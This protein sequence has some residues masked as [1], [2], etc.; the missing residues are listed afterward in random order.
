[1]SNMIRCP[2]VC[3]NTTSLPEISGDAAL[4]VDPENPEALAQAIANV[5][6]SHELRDRMR[7]RGLG[8]AR[9]FSWRRHTTET[10]R[11]LYEVH[12]GLRGA[13][14]APPPTTIP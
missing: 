13:E 4:L 5:I 9:Q 14:S 1:M 10:L 2:V 11:V 3:S 6:L 12:Q 8:R 7:E